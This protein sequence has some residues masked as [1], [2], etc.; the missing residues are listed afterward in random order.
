MTVKDIQTISIY[1]LQRWFLPQ[2]GSILFSA[3]TRCESTPATCT[4]I[5]L[6]SLG[7]GLP[8]FFN[9]LP[10]PRIK[11]SDTLYLYV[12][13]AFVYL[14]CCYWIKPKLIPRKYVLAYKNDIKKVGFCW[15]MIWSFHRRTCDVNNSISPSI[16]TLES[17]ARI[18]Y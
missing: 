17:L 7:F 3:G 8:E 12:R 2:L 14:C 4:P 1:P 6:I 18:C 11:T 5:R 10:P 13:I 9:A 16:L 15:R